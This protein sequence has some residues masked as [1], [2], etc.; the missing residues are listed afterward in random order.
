MT[1]APTKG[2]PVSLPYKPSHAA[3][4][5]KRKS[6]RQGSK[7]LDRTEVSELRQV[8]TLRRG[9]ATRHAAFRAARRRQRSR[10][11][12]VAA[13]SVPLLVMA[14]A[15]VPA[16]AWA[17]TTG[18][19]AKTV[20]TAAA[21]PSGASLTSFDGRP[22]PIGGDWFAAALAASQTTTPATAPAP[23]A[24]SV[25]AP[26]SRPAAPATHAPASTG[27]AQ[28]TTAQGRYL[29]TFVVTCYDLAGHTATGATPSTATVAV[30]P[31]VI[32]LGTHLYIDGAG[33]RVAQ[34][35]G[36]AIK[37][38]RLDIWEPTYAQCAAWGVEDRQVWIS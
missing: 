26:A 6:P 11:S 35:T 34:D 22:R 33:Q 23:T 7:E 16:I 1:G 20:P 10:R 15:A 24:T 13:S 9:L 30:D 28:L 29:G 3:P 38:N 18:G 4:R 19:S 37:G 8:A 17:A 2:S 21:R 36:G 32:P 27:T 25:A 12:K 14:S 5:K 31:R